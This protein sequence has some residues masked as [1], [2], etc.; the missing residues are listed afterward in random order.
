ML[1]VLAKDTHAVD[2]NHWDLTKQISPYVETKHFGLY[3]SSKV[4]YQCNHM[5]RGDDLCFLDFS[6]NEKKL[7]RN[8]MNG[9]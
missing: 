1:T 6:V 9:Q 7:L 2:F 8:K 3:A 5:S 4:A